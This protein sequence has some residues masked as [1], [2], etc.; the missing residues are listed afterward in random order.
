MLGEYLPILLFLAVS[1]AVGIAL[2]GSIMSAGYSS[3]VSGSTA[4]LPAEAATAV[5]EGIGGAVAVASAMGPEGARVMDA[6]RSAF[7]DG[8][9][10][11]MWVSAALA[12]GVAVL[13]AFWTPSGKSVAAAAEADA[14]DAVDETL[15]PV[16]GK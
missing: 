7:L 16:V 8:W 10:L 13:A 6:A 12:L 15:S 5:E 9:A 14:R 1:S 3:A 4:G 11:S 2:L